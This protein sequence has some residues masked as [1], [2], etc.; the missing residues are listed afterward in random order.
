MVDPTET[1]LAQDCSLV[2]LRQIEGVCDRR[3]FFLGLPSIHSPLLLQYSKY[4]W[5]RLN[6]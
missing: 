5:S 4:T 2:N 3:L 1:L 6:T